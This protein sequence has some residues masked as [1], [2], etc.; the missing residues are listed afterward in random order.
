MKTF[1]KIIITVISIIAIILIAAATYIHFST[2][3]PSAAAQQA[4]K[5]S[6]VI[7]KATVFK[8]KHNKMTVIFYTGAMVKPDSYSIWAKQVAQAG[9]TVKIV[10]FPLNMAFF[11]QNAAD[12]LAGKNKNYVVG[13]HSLGGAMASRYAH[14]S[15]NKHLRG[16]FLLGAYADEKG[17][18]DK[19]NLDVLSITATNDKVLN[20]KNYEVNKK[21]LPTNTKFASIKGGNHAGFGSY[22]KQ[23]GDGNTTISNA[24]QQKEVANLLI[25]WLDKVKK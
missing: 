19:T 11:N 6:Q 18:L 21:Y 16:L 20:W 12:N 17:R 7:N 23:K 4:A 5:S 25:K 1:K 13:G 9:Y 3:Q 24:T 22:G 14:N 10:H 15:H 2:Y 8:A